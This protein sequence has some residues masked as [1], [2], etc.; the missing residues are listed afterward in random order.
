MESTVISRLFGTDVPCSSTKPLTGHM[1]GAAGA[2]EAALSWLILKE[3]LPLPVQTFT[4]KPQD[5]TL[6]PFGLLTRPATLRKPVILS[7]SF[8][9]G[10]NNCVLIVG[11]S[12]TR[13]VNS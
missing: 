9:F 2:G 3:N 12:D 1:L 13:G 4:D 10:G 8:A 7:N 5:T 11:R 6:A